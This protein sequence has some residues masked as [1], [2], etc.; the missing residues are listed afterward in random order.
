MKTWQSIL[1]GV[2]CGL[3]GT[4]I[5]YLIS[6]PARGAPIRLLPAPSPVPLFVQIEGAVHHPGMV[7]LPPGSR[8]NDAVQAAGGLLAEADPGQINLA[9]PLS[10]GSL[11][12]IPYKAEL[13]SPAPDETDFAPSPDTRS[14]SMIETGLVNINTATLEELV[15]LPEIGPVIA[16][17]ILD[18]RQT[19]GPF[20]TLEAI[21]NVD[22]IGPV[23]FE[24]IKGL[25]TINPAP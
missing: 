25:I 18:Y 6:R 8:L 1:F 10:D 7:Q 14:G 2:L 5:L 12:T 17:R 11:V 23:T 13:N 24:Q 16:Q 9:A 4:G 3:L 15:N 22:G 21:Q 20:T 19:N